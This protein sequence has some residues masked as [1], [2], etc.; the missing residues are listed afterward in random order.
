MTLPTTTKAQKFH[1]LCRVVMDQSKDLYAKNYARTGLTL[2]EDE[3][4]RTQALYILSN[5]N[6]WRGEIARAVKAELKSL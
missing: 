2:T 1:A 5:L 3:A 4:I 6:Y